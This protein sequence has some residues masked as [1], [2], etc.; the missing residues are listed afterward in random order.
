MDN[1]LNFD[2]DAYFGLGVSATIMILKN[3]SPSAVIYTLFD[4]SGI[5]KSLRVQP[6]SQKPSVTEFGQSTI[7]DSQVLA[8]TTVSNPI[9]VVKMLYSVDAGSTGLRLK[10]FDNLFEWTKGNLD[11]QVL[12]GADV[13]AGLEQRN[14]MYT[15]ASSKDN[16]VEIKGDFIIDQNTA[17]YVEVEAKTTIQI[18]LVVSNNDYVAP[19]EHEINESDYSTLIRPYKGLSLIAL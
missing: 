10:Q 16:L 19:K 4:A 11:G 15:N 13:Q 1:K 14:W 17:C 8:K 2:Q 5:N 3:A 18:V 7:S 9:K 6:T 12:R